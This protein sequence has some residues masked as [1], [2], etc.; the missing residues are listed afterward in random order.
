MQPRQLLVLAALGGLGLPAAW[1]QGVPVDGFL[2]MV[3]IAL[4]DE[5]NNDFNF[6]PVPKNSVGGTLLGPGGTPHYDVALL[7]TG[8]G[9]SLITSKAYDDF[10]LDG[11][12]SGVPE[13]NFHGTET[14]AVGGA[15][16]QVI[17]SINDP[18]G[19]YAGGLQGRSGGGALTMNHSALKG[20]ANTSTITMPATSEL[21]NVLGLPF[22][23]QYATRIRNDLP[24]VFELDGKTV[25]T[26]GIEFLPLGS[27][28]NGITRKAPM[29]LNPGPSFASPPG[30]L[31]NIIDFD[32]DEPQE[33]PILPTAIQGG[34]FVNVNASNEGASLG[35]SQ[36]FFDTG[37]SVTVVSQLKALQLGFD[38]LLDEPEFTISVVGSGGTTSDVPGFF[39]EQFTIVALGGSI[40]ATNVPVIVLDVTN[41]ADAGNIVDGIVGT[42]LLSGRNLVI[43][44]NPSLGGG[45]ASAGLYISDPV[46][47]NFVWN[48]SA[49]SAPWS[50]S[51]NWN[52]AAT[53]GYL[54]TTKVRHVSGGAQEAVVSGDQQAWD[55][56]VSG[57]SVGQPMTLRIASGGKL[58]TFSGA[59]VEAGGVLKLEN[60]TLDAQF[61]DIRGG[62][63]TGS[64]DIRTGSGPIDGQV[65][66]VFGSVAPG[67]G[68]GTLTVNGR[69]SMGVNATLEIEVGGVNPGSEYDQLIVNGPASLGGTL[70][71]SLVNFN[72]S[73]GA[74]FEIMT[75]AEFGGEFDT[76]SLPMGYQWDVH[77]NSDS[78]V[79]ELTGIG[80]TGDFN[81]DGVVD[82]AD[83]TVWRDGLG[84]TY[85]QSHYA[86]WRAHYGQTSINS[87]ASGLSAAPEPG[88]MALLAALAMMGVFRRPAS[89]KQ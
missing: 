53:P 16:G 7:D 18:F 23:S 73:F 13:G 51:G 19:L 31:P 25:R 20:Q 24:Q 28:G 52:A 33:D 2:P 37:A 15:T 66:A 41:P 87:P 26:P 50:T 14:I 69:F 65:E 86:Q 49:A 44:P 80:L 76:L 17:A 59:T 64:G 9:L 12:Y 30:Y 85:D 4:T 6:Y 55:V 72:P 58:T 10:N 35:N 83:Y 39:V 48:S 42:N 3:G 34:L 36:F 21:P 43:D 82:A 88:A 8:A 74:T 89:I 47:T 75:Y 81:S 57:G 56:V 79:L 68:V 11:P 54:S 5:Y 70:A 22:A 1:G 27:G 78:V 71:V 77:Y 46:T 63:L 67:D 29:N 84:T 60:A 38:V 45:G 61:V 62:R 40:T 32:I